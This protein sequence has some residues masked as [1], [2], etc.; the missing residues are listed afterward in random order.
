MA[1]MGK[2]DALLAGYRVLDLTNE[3]G[4][5]CGK[6]LGDFGADVI[7]IEPPGGD[8]ARNIGPFY[9]DVLHPE[10]SLFCWAFNTSKRSITLNIDNAEGRKIFK[11]LV[12]TADFVIESFDPGY[13][14]RLGLGYTVLEQINPRI[15]MTSITPFGQTGPHA[16][17]KGPDIIPWAMGGFMCLCGDLEPGPPFRVGPPQSYRQASLHAATASMVAHY[18][19]E[20]TGE[21]QHLDVSMQQATIGFLCNAVEAWDLY[22]INVRGGGVGQMI[23]RPDPPGPLRIRFHWPCKDGYINFWPGGGGIVSMAL[24]TKAMVEMA[25]KQGMAGKLR[26]YDWTKFDLSQISQE[27]YDQIEEQFLKFFQTKKKKEIY[28]EAIK[29]AIICC[30]LN[31]T[32]DIVKDIQLEARGY[33]I[34]LDHPEIGD[35]IIYPGAPVKLSEAPW[36]VSRRPP[37]IGEHNQEIYGK[38]LGLTREEIATLNTLGVI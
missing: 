6:I 19:R 28:D 38:E 7:K 9:K 1:E 15:I 33:F 3:R 23:A 4:F 18:Y 22:R 14:D 26:D 16:H 31:T 12:K 24:S 10:R 17:Y 36:R 34:R 21:G 37:L 2:Q 13:M 11:N 32:E 20:S 35:T 8:P 30:P 27:E 25:D 5:L 29:K